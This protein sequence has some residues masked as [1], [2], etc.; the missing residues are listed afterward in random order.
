MLALVRAELAKVSSVHDYSAI[1]RAELAKREGWSEADWRAERDVAGMSSIFELVIESRRRSEAVK[2][3]QRNAA[4][5]RRYRRKRQAYDAERAILGLGPAPRGRPRRQAAQGS[6]AG[7]FVHEYPKLVAEWDWSKNLGEPK[8]VPAGSGEMIWWKC[9]RGPDHEY[10]AQ[11]RSRTMRGTDC[12]FCA[13]RRVAPSDSLAI[14]HPDIAAEWH[15][16][17]NKDLLPTEVTYGSH[18][19][20]W[21]QCPRYKTHAYR[22]R[23]SSR[24]SML[25]KCTVCRP[26]GHYERRDVRQ[27]SSGV[28]HDST[29]SAPKLLDVDD[30]MTTADAR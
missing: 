9:P 15:P 24:T 13:H 18:R 19:E 2:K 4:K 8:Q 6:V 14:S 27:D 20:V 3:P 26:Q 16:T 10:R 11:V 21:W 22:T 23:I 29:S 30:E 28:R 12:P 1:I 17:R 5:A 7:H 25:V